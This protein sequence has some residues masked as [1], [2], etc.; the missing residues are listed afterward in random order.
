VYIQKPSKIFDG[1]HVAFDGGVALATHQPSH[2]RIGVGLQNLH[3]DIDRSNWKSEFR[4]KP[5]AANFLPMIL[6][7]QTINPVQV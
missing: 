2:G 5:A 3:Q 4:S 1:K 7:R 6:A